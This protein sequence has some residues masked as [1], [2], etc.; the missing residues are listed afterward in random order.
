M[1]VPDAQGS[2]NKA[3]EALGLDLEMFV[4][5]PVGACN[6]ALHRGAISPVPILNYIPEILLV[7]H[8]CLCMA[9]V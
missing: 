1:S 5:G 4:S 7:F 2:R 8:L 6:S 3:S 9:P